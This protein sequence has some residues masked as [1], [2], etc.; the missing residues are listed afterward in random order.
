ME[1]MS[2]KIHNPPP[3]FQASQK[4]SKKSCSGG[5]LTSCHPYMARCCH[6]STGSGCNGCHFSRK[7]LSEAIGFPHIEVNMSISA[8][9]SVF[10]GRWLKVRTTHSP[11]LTNCN[12]D[13]NLSS[14][15][16]PDGERGMLQIKLIAHVF[17]M[18]PCLKPFGTF[19]RSFYCPEPSLTFFP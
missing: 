12:C 11:Y 4:S 14:G 6:L 5:A 17:C 8:N 19:T 16:I 9:G 15:D 18:R 1:K 2:K 10:V 3:A 13:Y 7:N